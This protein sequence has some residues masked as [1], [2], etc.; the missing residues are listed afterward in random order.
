MLYLL[1]VITFAFVILNFKLNKK[2]W[3][4]PAVIFS[5]VFF[6][7]TFG[8]VI[9]KNAYDIVFIPMTVFVI[10]AGIVVF[11]LISG[12]I[13]RSAGETVVVRNLFENK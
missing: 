13:E 8:C 2:D 1:C 7:Y 6:L 12:S 11:T 10:S 4:A 5:A 9:E 3:M